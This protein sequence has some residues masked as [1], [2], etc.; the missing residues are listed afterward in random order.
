MR[1]GP[2]TRPARLA[3]LPHWGGSGLDDRSR[4][5]GPSR[6]P[7]RARQRALRS[8]RAPLRDPA[9]VA[10]DD[11]AQ[12]GGGEL[13]AQLAVRVLRGSGH[14]GSDSRD[15]RPEDRFALATSTATGHGDRT[16]R[17]PRVPAQRRQCTRGVERRLRALAQQRS[18][19]RERWQHPARDEA[20]DDD[21]R[22]VSRPSCARPR[23]PDSSI[24]MAPRSR[25]R[26][27]RAAACSPC[28]LGRVE[29]LAGNA[30][31]EE[32]GR[33]VDRLADQ[34]RAEAERDRVHRAE[35]ER[36]AV[37]PTRGPRAQERPTAPR[38][39]ASDR[40]RGATASTQASVA[41]DAKR[42]SDSMAA[43]D[44]TARRPGP[45][46]VSRASGVATRA[47]A[48]RMLVRRPPGHRD[49]S[50]PHGSATRSS[51]RRR[52]AENQTPS[53]NVRAAA[54]AP[55]ATGASPAT[56]PSDRTAACAR[57]SAPAE[58][59]GAQRIVE[60]GA[61]ALGGEAFCAHAGAHE[62]APASQQ[63]LLAG[64]AR[65]LA[66]GDDRKLRILRQRSSE[67][68][69]RLRQRVRR[70]SFD[71]DQDQARRDPFAQLPDEQ[72][73]RRRR[74]GRQERREV[75]G[76]DEP[77]G[78]PDGRG[79]D[80]DGPDR[81]RRDGAARHRASGWIVVTERS[82]PASS[83]SMRCTRSPAPA[84]VTRSTVRGERGIARHQRQ[85]PRARRAGDLDDEMA[86]ERRQIAGQ[87]RAQALGQR[88][89]RA[90]RR[91]RH[92]A[93]GLR[94]A[95]RRRRAARRS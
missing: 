87:R 39:T 59:R 70:G 25:R 31:R 15:R 61:E 12:V 33:V 79:A 18:R 2:A 3:A 1:P 56:H 84:K 6:S 88:P 73:L 32:V 5:A 62:I 23:K 82:P 37:T 30:C 44:W 46:I 8:P 80:R 86:R 34:H 24:A 83:T 85:R 7:C 50:P 57:P 11:V 28:A 4:A 58:T 45:D 90:A 16:D 78:E 36:T 27:P 9:A 76:H 14:R 48:V 66:V 22:Q 63:R 93:P 54:S 91:H 92:R 95:A 26:A 60:R 38:A 10:S 55:L 51:A 13:C 20:G 21:A 43:R 77:A 35:H 64:E 72:A 49:R 71:R 47:N 69:A 75:G 65:E 40:S 52:S 94:P 89:R 17:E 67:R 42:A 68:P 53:C 29:A 74:R 81:D 41:S 19:R